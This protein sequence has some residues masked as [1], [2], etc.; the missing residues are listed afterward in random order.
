MYPNELFF[1]I[2]LYDLCLA[3][4][5]VAALVVFR[6]LSDKLSLS[7]QKTNLAL[8]GGLVGVFLGL[9][10]ATLLQA[11]YNFMAGE[12]FV[13]AKNTGATFYGGLLGGILGFLA[14]YLL[15]GARLLPKGEAKA[16][17][18]LVSSLAACSIAVAHGIGRVGCFFAGCCHGVESPFGIY[19]PAVGAR[20]LPTQLIEALFLFALA[21]FLA[22]RALCGKQNGFFLYLTAYGVFRFFLEYLRGDYRG[23]SLVSFLTPSQLVALLMVGVGIVYFLLEDKKPRPNREEVNGEAP[24]TKTEENE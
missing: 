6:L 13:I 7:A 19:L 24:E 1:G 12:G 2:T 18:P 21:A 15:G 3:L 20:V 17:L 5:V 22:N 14:V 16:T 23:A 11:F 8:G 10:T 4:G 9:G